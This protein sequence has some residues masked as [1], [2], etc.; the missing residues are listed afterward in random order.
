MRRPLHNRVWLSRPQWHWYGWRTA[1]P[2]YWG[3]DEY[4][5]HCWVFGWT[6]TGR[7]SLAV[8][9]CPGTGKCAEDVAE[10]GLTK[11][12]VDIYSFD[13]RNL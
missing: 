12:P 11:W 7:V 10:R 5:W 13:Q 2:F 4:D 1:V 3:G 9:P 8:R 6:I